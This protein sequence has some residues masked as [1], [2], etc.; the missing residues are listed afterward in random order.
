MSNKRSDIFSP[1]KRSQVMSKVRSKDTKPEIVIRRLL[2]S[3]GYRFR[4]YRKELPGN[5]DIV[6]PKYKTV[7][8]VN[9]CFWHQ[10]EGC[11]KSKLPISNS[12]FWSVKLQKNVERDKKNIERLEDLGWQVLL[13]WECQLRDLSTI[14]E[15]IINKMKRVHIAVND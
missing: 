2:H 15:M 7:I 12:L 5:P 13:I 11:K 9:G 6:L 8:F 14:E 10:H 1:E 3:L 4:L